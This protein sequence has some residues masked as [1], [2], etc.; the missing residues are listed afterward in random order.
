MFAMVGFESIEARRLERFKELAQFP[1]TTRDVALVAPAAMEHAEIV[2]FVRK[3]KLPDLEDVRLFD[4]FVDN[5]LRQAGKKSMAYQFTFRN[6]SRT[7]KDGE[8]NAVMEK[9]RGE[10]AS[11]LKLELR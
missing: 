7:L 1:A 3:C 8:V 4:V 11:K 5:A 9:L 6:R 10:L 2:D